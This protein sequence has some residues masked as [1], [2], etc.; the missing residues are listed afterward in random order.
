MGELVGITPAT[1]TASSLLALTVLAIIFGWLVPRRTLRDAL[2]ERDYWRNAYLTEC[3]GHRE[4]RQQNTELL[5]QT[6]VT[7]QIITARAP[8]AAAEG[9]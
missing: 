2:T 1:L 7:N 4:T 9:A 8:S 6:R 3:D 5:E